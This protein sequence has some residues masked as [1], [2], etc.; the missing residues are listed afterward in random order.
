MALFLA[1]GL[2]HN[3]S[4]PCAPYLDV[5]INFDAC[6]GRAFIDRSRY[7]GVITVWKSIFGTLVACIFRAR[8]PAIL[9]NCWSMPR[10]FLCTAIPSPSCRQSSLSPRLF[11]D[12]IS[13]ARL[14]VL[15]CPLLI[16]CLASSQF[17]FVF[18]V[19]VMFAQFCCFMGSFG[20]FLL[21]VCGF[22]H[23]MYSWPRDEV[24]AQVPFSSEMEPTQAQAHQRNRL[25]GLITAR[26]KKPPFS[27]RFQGAFLFRF[28]R[29]VSQWPK[30]F[31]VTF[32]RSQNFRQRSAVWQ[33]IGPLLVITVTT[34]LVLGPVMFSILSVLP[35][36][37]WAA[38]G[39]LSEVFISLWSSPFRGLYESFSVHCRRTFFPGF[40]FGVFS[41]CAGF[42]VSLVLPTRFGSLLCLSR[43]QGLQPVSVPPLFL[44]SVR[45]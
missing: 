15:S 37:F 41:V 30:L 35:A 34:S 28:W 18:R 17:V 43:F 2:V 8:A 13:Q 39:A 23:F 11:V 5:I 36:L 24:V 16:L 20:F 38:L 26:S 12:P 4:L 1:A 45:R 9:P 22:P 10:I 19:S 3:W 29:G 31:R 33:A 6:L 21:G 7:C 32:Q 27:P 44:G 42:P 14:E 40:S 25:S